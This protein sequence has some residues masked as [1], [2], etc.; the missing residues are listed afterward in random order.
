M[1][2]RSSIVALAVTLVG[3]TSLLR[4]DQAQAEWYICGAINQ[5]NCTEPF[6]CS[7]VCPGSSVIPICVDNPSGG[8]TLNCWSQL[9]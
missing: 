9:P 1:I 6:D 3:S 2:A 8:V 4:A 7:D 5:Q